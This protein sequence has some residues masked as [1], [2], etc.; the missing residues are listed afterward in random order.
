MTG[1][2]VH[3]RAAEGL[4]VLGE[5]QIGQRKAVLPRGCAQDPHKHSLVSGHRL[6][7]SSLIER[8]AVRINQR[9]RYQG[10]AA[11]FSIGIS[12]IC[13]SRGAAV[14]LVFSVVV[15]HLLVQLLPILAPLLGTQLEFRLIVRL[16]L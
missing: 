3:N 13:G 16:R 4:V 2:L 11:F 7:L 14:S 12:F 5:V 6:A 10:T 1:Y 15:R 9:E 8:N